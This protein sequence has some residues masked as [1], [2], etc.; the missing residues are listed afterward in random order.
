MKNTKVVANLETSFG[1]E[2]HVVAVSES[3]RLIE[4][5]VVLGKFTRCFVTFLCVLTLILEGVNLTLPGP[6]FPDEAK[7]KGKIFF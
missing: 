4:P 1:K 7:N 3:D 2:N 5:E 6:F